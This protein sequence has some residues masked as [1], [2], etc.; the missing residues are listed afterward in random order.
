MIVRIP[1]PAPQLAPVATPA[2][3]TAVTDDARAAGAAWTAWTVSTP[4]SDAEG[5]ANPRETKID[6]V[7]VTAHQ[8]PKRL[9]VVGGGVAGQ[10]FV[11]RRFLHQLVV[12]APGGSG[13][14]Q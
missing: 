7:N 2:T 9:L 11:A 4:A 3:A 12:P 6:E 8:F 14:A 13:Q 10:Q 5:T 1:V